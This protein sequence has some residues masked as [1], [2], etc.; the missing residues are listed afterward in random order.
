M[1]SVTLR[2]QHRKAEGRMCGHTSFC[3]LPFAI[4][5]LPPKAL[6]RNRTPFRCL[7]DSHVT[8]TPAG[9]LAFLTS[10]S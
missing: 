10:D 3:L 7:Q 6:P 2:G 8:I 9:Q 4:C 5:L 1:R